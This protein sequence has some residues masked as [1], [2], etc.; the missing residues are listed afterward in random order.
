VRAS[1]IRAIAGELTSPDLSDGSE[2]REQLEE[3]HGEG[4]TQS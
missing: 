1:F 2:I 4:L 3:V